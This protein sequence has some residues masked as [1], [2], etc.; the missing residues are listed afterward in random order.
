M[1]IALTN[2]EKVDISEYAFLYCI[3]IIVGS[4]RFT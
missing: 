2:L 3:V 1:N 4:E